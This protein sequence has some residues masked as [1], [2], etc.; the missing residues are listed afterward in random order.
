MGKVGMKRTLLLGSFTVGL[1]MPFAGWGQ[2]AEQVAVFAKSM[3]TAQQPAIV[4]TVVRLGAM[5]SLPA[6]VWRVHPGDIPHGE[7]T[8]LT[9]PHGQSRRLAISTQRMRSGFGAG[10]RSPSN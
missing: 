1:L 9:I 4:A 7:S 2:S 3:P 10:L 5:N 8:G 6:G